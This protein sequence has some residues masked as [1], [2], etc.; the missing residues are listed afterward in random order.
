[1]ADTIKVVDGDIQI[2]SASGRPSVVTGSMKLSQDIK[3]FFEVDVQPNGFGAGIERLVGLI[4]LSD[5]LFVTLVE[6]QIKDGMD[7]FIYAQNANPNT[8]RTDAERIV[9]VTG[10]MIQRDP[11]DQTTFYFRANLITKDGKQQSITSST[12]VK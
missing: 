4:Q 6:R 10:V 5:D 2:S 3:E 9:N 12:R 1:M 11:S 7:R 8:P